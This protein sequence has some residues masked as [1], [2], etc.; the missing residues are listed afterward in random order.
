MAFS[1][2]GQKPCDNLI[3]R[4]IYFVVQY[5]VFLFSSDNRVKKGF[6]MMQENSMEI[7]PQHEVP[8]SRT[9]DVLVAG[10]GPAGIAA[11]VAAAR[12]GA[13]TL[14]VERFGY[15]GGMM[16]GAHVVWVLG[17][18]DGYR[19]LI[20]GIARDI[21]KRLEPLDAI[22]KPNRCGDY[23]VDPEVFKWQAVEMI[24]ELGSEVLCHTMV[25]DPIMDG[26]CVRGV[27]T[28]SKSGRQAIR[29]K[30][31]V[32]CTADADVAFRGG[33]GFDNQT[34]DITLCLKFDGIDR[35][36]ADAFE[37]DDPHRF[38]QITAEACN[39]NGGVMPTHSRYMKDIDATDVDALSRCEKQLRNDCFQS[40]NYLRANMPGWEKAAI[41][42]TLPQLGV[43][44]SRRIHGLYTLSDDDLRSS[45]HFEDSI[46]RIGS[47][48]AGYKMN[49]PAGLDYDIPLRC[50]VPKDI[51]GLLVAGRC[52]SADYLACN[53]LRL[54]APCFVTGQAA[55]V[56]AAIA[57][58]QNIQPR[59]VPAAEVR[60]SL[61]AQNV[62]LAA[63][64]QELTTGDDTPEAP[65]QNTDGQ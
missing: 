64:G 27:Y 50:L 7:E 5:I 47:Y 30:V 38:A 11:G 12:E 20:R 10:G 45:R 40:L 29:A 19:P 57:A 17:M 49:D 48:L 4:R 1:T 61:L 31:V 9:V 55:G 23:A 28:E 37:K 15:L 32:D 52:V 3:F 35:K 62:Y 6:S 58:K 63:P 44:Q 16:T 21:R 53:T 26:S 22:V 25:C 36:K 39:L 24:E 14:V 54:I 46:G 2:F 33:C 56:T 42:E 41:K 34:H 60:K 51:D 65:L 43:R 8:V 18:G 13:N 59:S